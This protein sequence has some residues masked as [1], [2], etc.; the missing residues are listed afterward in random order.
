[1][2]PNTAPLNDFSARAKALTVGKFFTV[3]KIAPSGSLEARKLS[4]GTVAF[5]WRYTANG[6]S[7]RSHIGIYAASNP[8]KSIKPVVGFYSLNAA[9]ASA[10]ALAGEHDDSVKAGGGGHADI[11]AAK[12]QATNDLIAAT[13]ARQANTLEG[14]LR[15]YVDYLAQQGKQSHRDV[16]NIVTNHL[17]TPHPAL[18]SKAA[19]EVTAENIADVIRCVIENGKPRTANKLRSYLHAAF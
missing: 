3:C 19:C 14:L 10:T 18:A 2:N 7:G 4:N 11:K 6:K 9:L 17:L 16:L 8:P 5:Y 15:L 13:Q 1:M 12:K